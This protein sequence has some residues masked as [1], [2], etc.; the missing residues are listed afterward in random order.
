MTDARL[1]TL[2]QRHDLEEH[3]EGFARLKV[4]LQALRTIKRSR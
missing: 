3:L 2:L 1:R 4:D